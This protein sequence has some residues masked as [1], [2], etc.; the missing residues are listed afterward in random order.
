MAW[1]SERL[2]ID[3]KMVS[4]A[5]VEDIGGKSCFMTLL[6]ASSM[7]EAEGMMSDTR[8]QGELLYRTEVQI[9]PH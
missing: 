8:S 2:D 6:S 9:S 1:G 4:P 3:E 7:F 5:S